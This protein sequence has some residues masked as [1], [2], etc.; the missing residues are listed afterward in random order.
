LQIACVA[1][2]GSC[3]KNP[4]GRE[5]GLTRQLQTTPRGARHRVLA[6]RDAPFMG[7]TSHFDEVESLPQGTEG[8]LTNAMTQV[9]AAD[10]HHENGQFF[11]VQYHPEYDFSE[12]A[13]LARFRA[14]GLIQDATFADEASLQEFIAACEAVHRTPDNADLRHQLNIDDS[15]LDQACRQNELRNW[16]D[17][18]FR[19][20]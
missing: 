5:F 3:R 19:E 15:V 4:K 2:G 11:A 17:L 7:F 6:N 18:H 9:Q 13:A 14:D 20:N 1:A 12:I 16:L 10:I 8:L